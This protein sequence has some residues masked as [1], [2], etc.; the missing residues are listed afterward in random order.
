[1]LI[2][3]VLKLHYQIHNKKHQ[4]KQMKTENKKIKT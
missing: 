2:N 1:M 3:N 4:Y